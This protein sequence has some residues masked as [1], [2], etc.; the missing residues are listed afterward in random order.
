MNSDEIYVDIDEFYSDAELQDMKAEYHYAKG[1]GFID[2]I[3]KHRQIG[4][5]HQLVEAMEDGDLAA[6]YLK[7]V[8][9]PEDTE[10]EV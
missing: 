6:E 2:W 4:N 9:L 8:G 7:E 5:G 10:L 1:Q 3:Y